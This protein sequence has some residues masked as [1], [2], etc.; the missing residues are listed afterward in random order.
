MW[1]NLSLVAFVA[2][3]SLIG[4]SAAEAQSPESDTADT[5]TELPPAP[6]FVVPDV[7]Q[8]T[9]ESAN[10][11]NRHLT[12]K[13]GLAALFDYTWFDQDAASQAQVGTQEDQFE[14]RSFR[15][16]GRGELKFLNSWNYMLSAE[17]K[18]FDNDPDG[19]DW[20]ISDAWVQFNA[21]STR[22]RIGK[23]KQPFVYEMVGDAANLPQN[24]R[25]LSPFFVSR[26][27]GVSWSGGFSRRATWSVGW[28]N[29]APVS[30]ESFSDNGSDVAARVTALPILEDDGARYLHL[31]ASARYYA[32]DKNNLRF[33]GRPESNVADNFVDTGNIPGDHAWLMGLEALWADHYYSV[34]AEYVH[35]W[36]R[37]APTDNPQFNGYY[38]TAS[39]VP[40]GLPRPYDTKAAYARRVPVTEAWGSLEFVLRYGHLD[41]DDA[42]VRGGTL[43]K[44]FAGINW[45]A[46]KRW[47]ASI[48]YGDA[49]LD[50]FDVTGNTRI[51]LTRI[52]WIY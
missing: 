10:V 37:S 12:F 28:F 32:G 24:E 4:M 2:M 1:R 47:K 44:W 52:Q 38:I 15:L 16:I 27:L 6:A 5:M 11:D 46:T 39:F 9:L 3:M 14:V 51:L 40:N 41:L 45:W 30:G 8:M 19:E 48:G 35:A 17:Y 21:G 25:L 33:K 26:S 43:D 34:L 50:R 13:P 31:A 36:V 7:A 23:Q 29:D 42:Q 22:I 20:Q 18:G 49:D